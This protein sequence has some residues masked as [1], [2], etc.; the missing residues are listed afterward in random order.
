[1]GYCLG[2]K[3]VM[4]GVLIAALAFPQGS[5]SDHGN[6]YLVLAGLITASLLTWPVMKIRQLL[7]RR[8]HP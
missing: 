7:S 6:A 8:R 3:G 2:E 5:E 4:N 1:L